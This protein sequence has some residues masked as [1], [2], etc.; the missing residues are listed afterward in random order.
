MKRLL[1]TGCLALAVLLPTAAFADGPETGV[2]TGT[3]TDA[4]GSPLPGVTV[5]LEGER[6][7]QTVITDENGSYRFALL[8]PGSYKVRATLE[9]F[10]ESKK[11]A[12]VSAGGKAEVDMEISM[13][14]AETITVTSEAPMVDKFNV[15]A[16]ATVSAEV[17]EQAAGQNR[18]YYGVVNML[19]GV[20]NDADNNDIDQMRPSVNGSHFADQG[21]YI[22][23]VDTTFSRL[24]GSRVILPTTA[25][26]EITMEAGGASAEYGRV[27]GSS[28]NVIVKSGTNKFHGQALGV[29]SK[30]SWFADYKDQPILETIEFGPAPRGFLKR[31]DREKD[32]DATSIEASVGGPLK[33]DKAWFFVAYNDSSTGNFDKTLNGDLIDA[34]IEYTAKIAKLNFQPGT[35]HQVAIS[36]MDSPI[37]RV[38]THPPSADEWTPTPHNLSGDLASLNWNFT[39]SSSLFLETKLASQTSN[40][41]KLLAAGTLDVGDAVRLKQQDPRFPGDPN[42]ADPCAYETPSVDCHTPGNNYRVYTDSADNGSWHNGWVLDNGFGLNEYPRDQFNTALTWFAS[43]KHEVKFGVD[44]QEVQ[45]L[46]D[47]RRTG[48]YAGDNFDAT[49]PT[50][51]VGCGFAEG[52]I[53]FWEDYNPA[54]LIARGRGSSDSTNRNTT[55]YARDRFTVGDHWTLNLGL[56][57][58]QQQ[59]TND[60]GNKVVDTTTIE[61]RVS[62]SYDVKG[63]GKMLVSLNTGRY[64]AQLNQQFTNQWL[65][66][67]WNGWNGFDDYLYCSATDVFLG[68]FVP[69]LAFCTFFGEGY[70]VPYRSFRPGRQF[71]LAEQGVIPPIDLDPYY[72]DE[73]I[74]GFEYQFTRNWAF[75]AKAIYWE[76]GDMIMNTTQRDPSGQTFQLS[77]NTKNI[78][79]IWRALGQ[80]PENLIDNFEDPYKKYTAAQIQI[81]KRF[82]NGW[83][84]YNNLTLA[85]LE[86]TGSGAWWNNTSSSYGEDLGEV[87]TQASIDSCQAM[88]ATR[89]YPV[90]CQAI[91]GPYL[92]TPLSTINRA[93]RDGLGGGIGA[94]DGAYG[95]G[96]DRPFIWKTFGFKQ[97]NVGKQM[98]SLGGL[99]TIQDGIAWGRGELVDAPSPNDALHD[100]WIPLESNGTRRLGSFYDLNLTGAWGFPLGGT[101]RGEWRVEATNVTDE[102]EQIN[103]NIYGEPQR[104]RRDFQRP[105]QIRTLVT[106]SF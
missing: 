28:T 104:V 24:G 34:S 46:Q 57:G 39:I 100:V 41:D 20:T 50:G 68:N 87:L 62:M 54:D 105:R 63:D 85:K 13:G 73:I 49:S 5:I 69:G 65:M 7:S 12:Q 75:D 101:V 77:T 88:Q 92:G 17:G 91:L 71:Q 32:L 81:N 38:Y 90:D 86:T 93:G 84:L 14:T 35:N 3:I 78:R 47:V 72:K 15:T 23:G 30:A 19:P 37:K 94:G 98:F 2:V 58:S 95:S 74:L 4:Q 59:N 89:T 96:V 36:Y 70:T 99:L 83:A 56:R 10:N 67:E 103:V 16:G 8:T 51:Y 61:P 53:C 25:T 60:V 79:D 1:L 66:E 6:G 64:Y 102:Q 55:L 22:D 45:W 26:T 29:Y 106:I 97:W 33:R 11:M 43:D 9:G 80:V 42:F 40:E 31:S 44:W 21:V 48:F 18:S 82:A 52:N 27:V 76:L